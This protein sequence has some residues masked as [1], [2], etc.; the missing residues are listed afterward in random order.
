MLSES[1]IKQLKIQGKDIEKVESQIQNFVNGFPFMQ[2]NRAA[3][4]GDG[5][6]HLSEEELKKAVDFY[7]NTLGDFEIIKFVPASGAASRMFKDLFS[8]MNEYRGTPEDMVKFREAGAW[9]SVKNFFDNVDRFA[10][11]E[12]LK[13]TI[14]KDGLNFSDLIAE[15]KYQI[16]LQYVLTERGLNY[17]NLPK[18]LLQFHRY[19]QGART[20]LEEHLVEGAMYAR[21]NA[22]NTNLHFTVSPEHEEKFQEL[23]DQVLDDYSDS[24]KTQYSISFSTQK[25]ST[26]TIAVDLDNNP[27]VLEDGEILF[28]PGGHGAL[29]ENLNDLETDIVFIK[30]IDN[31]VPDHL[32][33]VTV[34]YK[35]AL[36]G[37]LL[38][39]QEKIFYY[40]N[41][42]S[43]DSTLSPSFMEEIA[44]FIQDELCEELIPG[45]EIINA[46]EY[47]KK[48]LDRPI[49]ICGMVKNE[50]E[51]GGGPFWAANPDNTISLQ[52]VE[53]AQVD[54]ADQEQLEIARSATHFNPVDLICGIR[55]YKGEKFDLTKY[56]DP[57][58]GFISRKS[59]GGRDLKAL[60]LP[61]LWN[62][63]MSDWITIFVEVPIETFNPVKVV[64]DLLRPQHQ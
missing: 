56:V 20:P 33:E 26:D 52:V 40:L 57:Q 9:K 28:R 43:E 59:Q 6:I 29:I 22:K 47:F 55:N 39:F 32:K 13:S 35:K 48:K 62:G 30:N 53:S 5:I 61:G 58:T 23:V 54:P 7:D 17:G 50:G 46:G 45:H 51:P 16:V 15:G 2:L 44:A 31:V 36:A 4:I 41:I 3:T 21:S 63:S 19:E 42:L 49:R 64:N 60:E 1:S 14:G 18:G 34:Q 27:F 11:Y 8:F 25:P 24:Y 38:E 37:L 10:F 12:D